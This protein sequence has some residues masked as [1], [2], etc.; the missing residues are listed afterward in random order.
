MPTTAFDIDC[1]LQNWFPKPD[2]FA[3]FGVA[4]FGVVEDTTPDAVGNYGRME[5]QLR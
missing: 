4:E 2:A 1:T 5:P 3:N